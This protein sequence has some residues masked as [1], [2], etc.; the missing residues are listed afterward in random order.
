MEHLFEY[1][2]E[3]DELRFSEEEKAAMIR[4]LAA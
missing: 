4:R 1:K 3:L 2:G